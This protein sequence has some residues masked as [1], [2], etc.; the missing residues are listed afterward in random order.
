MS[1]PTPSSQSAPRRRKLIL[2]LLAGLLLVVA[3]FALLS[4]RTTA[5]YW[6]RVYALAQQADAVK[7]LET[8]AEAIEVLANIEKQ[9]GQ[10]RRRTG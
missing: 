2:G 1:N 4:D 7:N 5:R 8:P 3:L 6:N 10:A 9:L